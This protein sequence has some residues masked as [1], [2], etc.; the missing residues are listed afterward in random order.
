MWITDV[1]GEYLELTFN[2]WTAMIQPAKGIE[3]VVE[4][5]GTHLIALTNQGFGEMG[6]NETIG[7]G[8]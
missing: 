5:E 8:D 3:G 1:A 7:T 4:H 6:T 2:V